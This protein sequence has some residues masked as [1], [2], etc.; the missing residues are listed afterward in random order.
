M[1]QFDKETSSNNFEWHKERLL[2][3]KKEPN[4]FTKN[5]IDYNLKAIEKKHGAEAARE[6]A[7]EYN[8]KNIRS[9]KYY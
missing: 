5:R 3:E 1:G 4:A 8:S 9:K 2:R 6:A 7:K